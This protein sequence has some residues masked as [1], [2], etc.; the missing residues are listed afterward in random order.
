MTPSL[1]P[2]KREIENL[3][4]KIA[5]EEKRIG[6]ISDA[7]FGNGGVCCPSCG[8]PGYRELMQAQDRREKWL[9]ILQ[10]KLQVDS[11][12]IKKAKSP[13][14]PVS[15]IVFPELIWP[16]VRYEDLQ[17]EGAPLTLDFRFKPPSLDI[18]LNGTPSINGFL[19]PDTQV[20]RAQLNAVFQEWVSN[21]EQ[22]K[23][24]P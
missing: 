3:E 21:Q 20:G 12:Q 11:G 5:R 2:L 7:F 8:E 16:I 22:A 13:S 17:R 9:A 14:I 15:R 10:T 24:E 18:D 1:S 19:I 6:E 23:R 4:K